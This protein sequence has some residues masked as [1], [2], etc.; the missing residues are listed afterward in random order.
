MSRSRIL[1]AGLFVACAALVALACGPRLGGGGK[2]GDADPVEVPPADGLSVSD[3]PTPDPDVPTVA[4]HSQPEDTRAGGGTQVLK[5]GCNRTHVRTVNY[6]GGYSISRNHYAEIDVPGLDPQNLPHITAVQCE[7]ELT[8]QECP[9][10]ATCDETG[11]P[12]I[13]KPAADACWQTSFVVRPGK[14]WVSCGSDSET[15]NNGGWVN[16]GKSVVVRIGQ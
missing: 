9:E 1:Q 3:A 16:R 10:N 11:D 13:W 14:L 12:D 8:I 5:Q 15:G 2:R 6:E 7:I 4:D